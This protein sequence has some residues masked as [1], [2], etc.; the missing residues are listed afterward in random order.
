MP[1]RLALARISE[2]AQNCDMTQ[3][4]RAL[5]VPFLLG[6]ASCAQV[7]QM[8]PMDDLE[9]V[10]PVLPQP[11]EDTCNANNFANR[12]GQ[13]ATSLETALI[14]DRVRIIRPD[15]MVTMDFAPSRINFYIDENETIT[16]IAC[17]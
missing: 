2:Q 14:L 12:I 10:L 8:P 1:A 15:T 5:L 13:P 9:P 17:G 16:R 6:L 11:D 3:M 4:M 7:A